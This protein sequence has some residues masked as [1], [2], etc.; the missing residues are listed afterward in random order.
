MA[1]CATLVINNNLRLTQINTIFRTYTNTGSTKITFMIMND[2]HLFSRKIWIIKIKSLFKIPFCSEKSGEHHEDI[3]RPA[4][5]N[6][7]SEKQYSK[8]SRTGRVFNVPA[9]DRADK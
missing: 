3:D 7:D 4:K 6:T 5:A 1:H 9:N 8:F 2:Y